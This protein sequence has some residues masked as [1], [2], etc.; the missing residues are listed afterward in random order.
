VQADF[1]TIVGQWANAG[2]IQGR[3]IS[4]C[5]VKDGIVVYIRTDSGSVFIKKLD[6]CTI[7]S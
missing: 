3:I 6:D 5:A 2:G 4:A 7:A 1:G